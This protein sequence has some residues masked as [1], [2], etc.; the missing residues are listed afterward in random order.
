MVFS[1]VQNVMGMVLL[2]INN[3][4]SGRRV[5]RVAFFVQSLSC[6]QLFATPWTV[7]YQA[8]LPIANSQSLLKLMSIDSVMPSNHLILCCPV[9]L[10]PSILNSIRVFSSQ[11]VLHIR[12]PKY[13]AAAAAAAAKSLQSCLT[14]CYSIDGSRSEERRV[15]KECRS[16]WSPYH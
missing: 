4:Y 7:A 6:V 14:L 11:S 8:S 12:C 9:L 15:G 2:S 13:I 16:R 3:G 10:L 5:K 1:A